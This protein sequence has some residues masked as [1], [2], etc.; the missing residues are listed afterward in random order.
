M[1]E[2]SLSSDCF[3]QWSQ[4]PS[5][6]RHEILPRTAHYRRLPHD[7][8]LLS[9][10]RLA[11]PSAT[12]RH[13]VCLQQRPPGRA[14]RQQQP[15]TPPASASLPWSKS[16]LLCAVAMGFRGSHGCP[17]PPPRSAVASPRRPSPGLPH[18]W[19]RL[20]PPAVH[21]LARISPDLAV[22]MGFWG[23]HGCPLSPPVVE[24]G[25]DAGRV[26]DGGDLLLPMVLFAAWIC[27]RWVGVADIGL[28]WGRWSTEFRCS[29]GAL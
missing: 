15:V 23:S 2:S 21:C 3:F 8:R 26:E 12:I 5:F 16:A 20:P 25:G 10:V 27:R 29:G 28:I 18:C 1:G 19:V 7:A 13:R 4:R 22:E 17:V 14:V 11:P 24:D 6:Y 9:V